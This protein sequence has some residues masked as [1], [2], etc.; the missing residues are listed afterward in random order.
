MKGAGAS[1]ADGPC[2]HGTQ[3][4]SFIMTTPKIRAGFYLV[5]TKNNS[6]QVTMLLTGAPGPPASQ[7]DPSL[8]AKL[9]QLG[10]EP[11]CG[12][13]AL[14]QVGEKLFSFIFPLPLESPHLRAHVWWS[15]GICPLSLAPLL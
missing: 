8:M 7:C 13:Q 4:R 11:V 10:V 2:A 9:M 5:N 3:P 12:L 6:V 14:R 1:E 15:Q